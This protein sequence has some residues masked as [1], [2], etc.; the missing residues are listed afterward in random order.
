MATWLRIQKIS[1]GFSVSWFLCFLTYWFQS[2][3]VSK[4]PSFKESN[5]LFN[6]VDGYRSHMI[7]IPFHVFWKIF[8]PYSRC[9]RIVWTDLLD[10][11]APAFP[12]FSINNDFQNVDIPKNKMFKMGWFLELF[13]VY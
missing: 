7:Q 12:N 13:E 3:K 9:L 5:F 10:L 6:I 1:T 2:F 11:P 8:I 4:F